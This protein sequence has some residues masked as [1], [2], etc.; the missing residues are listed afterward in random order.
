M[1]E[2]K[3]KPKKK[4]R[5]SSNEKKDTVDESNGLKV[6]KI[7]QN[8]ENPNNVDDKSVVEVVANE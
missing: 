4:K 3:S 1:P 6:E 5:G 2:S 7:K 8:E